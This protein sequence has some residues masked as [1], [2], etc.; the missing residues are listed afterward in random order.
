MA[1]EIQLQLPEARCVV[2]LRL[3]I[4]GWI[5]G[6]GIE[7][8]ERCGGNERAP[9]HRVGTKI[10]AIQVGPGGNVR[11][12]RLGKLEGCRTAKTVIDYV[13]RDFAFGDTTPRGHV[14]TFLRASF[15]A[16]ISSVV[17]AERVIELEPVKRLVIGGDVAEGTRRLLLVQLLIKRVKRVVEAARLASTSG[18]RVLQ[19]IR[20]MQPRG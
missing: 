16:L 13:V 1:N 11:P 9:N 20:A 10:P 8:A 6:E 2:D 15:K 4:A 14:G 5:A 7:H 18:S 3:I 17:R 12:D 19:P